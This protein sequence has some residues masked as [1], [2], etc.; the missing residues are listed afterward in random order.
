[1]FGYS[2]PGAYFEWQDVSPPQPAIKR[3][4]IAGFVGIASRGPLYQPVKIQSWTQFVSVF[5]GYIQQAYLAYAVEGFFANGGRTCWVVRVANTEGS[6][7]Q[8]AKPGSLVLYDD[9]DGINPVTQKETIKLVA[10]TP[11]TWSKRLV[12]SV[13]RTSE[14]RFNLVFRMPD[15]GQEV[16]P[17]LSMKKKDPRYI[18]KVINQPG[19]QCNL[20]FN[21]DLP[22]DQPETGL[23][24]RQQQTGSQWIRVELFEN[25]GEASTRPPNEKGKNLQAGTAR[26]KGGQDGLT[27]LAPSHFEH[28]LS[29]LEKVDEV[30]VVAIPDIMPVSHIPPSYKPPVPPDCTS[31]VDVPITPG[32]GLPVQ[33]QDP[34]EYPPVFDDTQ[35]K[36]LQDKLILHCELLKDRVAI[37][38][39]QMD[40]TT[41][42]LS[43]NDPEKVIALREPFSSSYAAVYYPW[44]SVPDPL[45]LTG[46]IRSIP[47]SGHIAGLYARID[48]ERGVHKPPANHALVN[49]EAAVVDIND[50]MH[51]VF[52]ENHINVI[53][54]YNGRGIRVSGARTLSI[55]PD[56]KYINVRR[57]LTM[58]SEVIDEKSQTFVFEPNNHDLWR[59]IER[60]VRNF[61]DLLWREGM[62]DGASAEQ[63]YSVRCDAETNPQNEL[64]NGRVICEIGLYL[65]W[66]AEFVVV[67]IGFTDSGASLLEGVA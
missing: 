55:D 22:N 34:V 33:D 67:R 25:D 11:G 44:I 38:D 59:Q 45:S 10:V 7:E 62:L 13:L 53:R 3:T 9:G 50:V 17:N 54:K 61:L 52:N 51:G 46:L 49:V 2:T 14:T 30:S 48:N 42:G 56:Y 58:I 18:C 15:G 5:G 32:D 43:V 39:L 29:Y 60:M 24:A 57:L 63:A 41:P 12:V 40:N 8:Q 16:W 66:P 6:V 26:L 64:D 1:M 23:I 19:F 36:H 20:G 65:P 37:I 27:N 4:D 31:L 35:I 28:G 47:P 21:P